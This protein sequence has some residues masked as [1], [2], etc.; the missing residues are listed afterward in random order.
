MPRGQG[1]FDFVDASPSR[2][3]HSAQDD[4]AVCGIEMT[5]SKRPTI[6]W[7]DILWLVFLAGLALLPPVVEY[8]KQGILLAF[9]VIQL[10]EGWLI[11]RMTRRGP[12]YLV[13]LKMV[14][15]QLLEAIT[16]VIVI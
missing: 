8:H 7:M 1:S 3:I 9:G 15:A 5:E 12:V 11:A 4:S 2:G 16:G 13:L 6:N 10:G 14:L